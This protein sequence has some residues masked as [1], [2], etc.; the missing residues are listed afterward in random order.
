MS[1]PA[2]LWDAATYPMTSSALSAHGIHRIFYMFILCL[3]PPIQ[4]VTQGF[5]KNLPFC[6][7]SSAEN[8]AWHVIKATTKKGSERNVS[9][10]EAEQTRLG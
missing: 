8:S 4:Q 2:T 7:V 10:P 3:S 6:Y 9:Q 5:S 1:S